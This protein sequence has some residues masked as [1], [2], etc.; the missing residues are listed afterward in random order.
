MLMASPIRRPRPPTGSRRNMRSNYSI[1]RSFAPW[2]FADTMMPELRDKP[3]AP[4]ALVMLAIACALLVNFTACSGGRT[5]E[6]RDAMKQITK[7]GGRVNYRT[8]GLE[9]D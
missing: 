8:N 1:A 3:F 6:E 5:D 2:W 7:L 4:T 9:V